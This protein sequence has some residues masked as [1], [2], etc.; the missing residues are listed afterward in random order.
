MAKIVDPRKL[1]DP[2][3]C[4]PGLKPRLANS[5]RLTTAIPPKSMLSTG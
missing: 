4:I 3:I 5:P 1:P 2:E